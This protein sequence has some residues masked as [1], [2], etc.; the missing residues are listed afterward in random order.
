MASKTIK[1]AF[2]SGI[3]K[4]IGKELAVGLKKRGYKVYGTCLPSEQWEAKNLEDVYGIKV[5]ALNVSKVEEIE[6][7]ASSIEQEIDGRIDFLYNNESV[8]I[9]GPAIETPDAD[10][11][12]LFKVNVL[13]NIYLTKYLS[14]YVI[15]AKGIIVFSSSATARLPVPWMSAYG[16]SKAA[17]DQYALIL[18]SELKPFGVLVHSVIIGNILPSSSYH[19]I[20]TNCVRGPYYAVDG[21]YESFKSIGEY[22]ESVNISPREASENILNKILSP[23]SYPGFNIFTGA[24]AYLSHVFV[25]YLPLWLVEYGVAFQFR[26]FKVWTGVR[27]KRRAVQVT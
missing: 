5:F 14:K 15:Q 16:A 4:G 24:R 25:R 20:A 22:T 26:L 10:L 9:G 18:R 1:R 13:G 11:E 7:L 3:T 17:V 8:V 19:G 2:I 6:K 27:R 21:I 12:Q 23:W